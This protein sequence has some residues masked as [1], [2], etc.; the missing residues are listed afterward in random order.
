MVIPKICKFTIDLFDRS[1][2]TV[3]QTSTALISI[4]NYT[5]ALIY[6]TCL[7][8][9]HTRLNVCSVLQYIYVYWLLLVLRLSQLTLFFN[10]N[11]RKSKF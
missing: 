8:H 11:M 1:G 2:G 9:L 4:T 7:E 6:N 5:K 3:T 10:F